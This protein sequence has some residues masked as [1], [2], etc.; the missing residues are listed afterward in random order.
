MLILGSAW[1]AVYEFRESMKDGRVALIY[2]AGPAGTFAGTKL[3]FLLADGWRHFH[4]FSRTRLS[5]MHPRGF[6]N[7]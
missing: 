3:A 2:A 4:G 1:G 5:E 7:G 6:Q